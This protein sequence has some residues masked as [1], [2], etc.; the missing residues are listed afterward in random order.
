LAQ[1]VRA[2]SLTEGP[3]S[4]PAAEGSKPFITPVSGDLIFDI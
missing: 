1:Q 3:G 2:L 4:I